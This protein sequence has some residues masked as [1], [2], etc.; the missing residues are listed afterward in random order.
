MVGVCS[1]Q[2]YSP[3]VRLLSTDQELSRDSHISCSSQLSALTTKNGPNTF[4]GLVSRAETEVE[5]DIFLKY[6]PLHDP[7]KHMVTESY[8]SHQLPDPEEENP[9]PISDHNN[10]S[11]VDG[12]FS[13]L[14]NELGAYFPHAPAYYGS[15]LAIK[16]E[17]EYDFVDECDYLLGT[18]RFHKNI[19]SV[20]SLDSDTIAALNLSRSPSNRPP[21]QL[22]EI[23]EEFDLGIVDSTD[24]PLLL[25]KATKEEADE[26]CSSDSS[27]TDSD[28]DDDLY[29]DEQVPCFIATIKDYPV[30][31]IAME[32]LEATLD[33]LLGKM[34]LS[35]DELAS[36]A[37]QII[38]ALI[39][40]GKAFDFTHNDLHT[41]NIMYV[42]TSKSYLQ[43]KYAGQYYR[44]PTFG[45]I[46]KIIDFGR[47]IYRVGEL[48]MV[49]DSYKS[50]GDAAGLFNFGPNRNEG[51]KEQWPNKSFDLCRLGCSLFEFLET[52]TLDPPASDD[53]SARAM[54]LRWCLNDKGKNMLY[55]KNGQERYPDFKLYKMIV[56]TVT[57]H[58]PED[59]IQNPVFDK[60]K[61]IKKFIQKKAKLVNIDRF[62][63]LYQ[64]VGSPVKT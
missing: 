44:V 19:G 12:F 45:K 55:K 23:D 1:P 2:T 30:N 6:S 47:S 41:S 52:G 40:Y 25:P 43:Y 5:E 62:G 63:P 32:K 15:F 28:S 27:N 24:A 20:F 54:M 57:T 29:E 21:I 14:C 22:S 59:E 3:V 56:K 60:F 17:F 10:A 34:E 11:Y 49:S 39:V 58:D 26:I 7:V 64:N 31:I 42:K 37:F 53:N 48:T 4:R 61:T 50:G 9:G 38:M 46:Y 13:H 36:M 16:K 8:V 51:F 35:D 33:T 18:D